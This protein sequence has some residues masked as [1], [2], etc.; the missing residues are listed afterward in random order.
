LNRKETLERI[1]IAVTEV[2]GY[3]HI[4]RTE[5]DELGIDVRALVN[6][7]NWTLVEGTLVYGILYEKSRADLEFGQKPD[8]KTLRKMI[9]EQKNVSKS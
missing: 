6:E 7:N 2:F 9:K 5:A 3:A 1:R 8:R 4:T